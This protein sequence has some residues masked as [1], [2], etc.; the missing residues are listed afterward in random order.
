MTA[1][2]SNTRGR[3]VN[4]LARAGITLRDAR[5]MSDRELLDAVPNFGRACLDWVRS[6]ED[7]VAP[8]IVCPYCHNQVNLSVSAL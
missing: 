2:A 7:V 8:T 3:A 1:V 4:A 6:E 5:G